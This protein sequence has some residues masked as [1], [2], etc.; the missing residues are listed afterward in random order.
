MS[1][2]W[3]KSEKPTWPQRKTTQLAVFLWVGVLF[4]LVSTQIAIANDAFTFFIDDGG[5]NQIDNNAG[6]QQSDLTQLGIDDSHPGSLWLQWSWDSTDLWTGN[7]QTGDACALFDTDGDG[8]ANYSICTAIHNP[9][10]NASTVTTTTADPFFYVCG[11]DSK[12]DRCANPTAQSLSCT[13]MYTAGGNTDTLNNTLITAT[14]PFVGGSNYP[15][16]STIML[17]ICTSDLPAGAQL[18]NICSF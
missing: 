14:D 13:D 9:G 8:F 7:G 5:V 4:C 11:G 10:G 18:L 1:F 16:D 6:G 15:N 12:T 17:Q 2:S 3:R